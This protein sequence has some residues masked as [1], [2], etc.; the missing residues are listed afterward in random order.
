VPAT[1]EALEYLEEIAQEMTR[2]F[3]ITIREARGRINTQ[4]SNQQFLTPLEVNVLTH[5]EQDVWAGHIYYGRDSFWW[6]GESD[7]Q[8]QPYT[9]DNSCET[10]PQ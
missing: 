8:P 2:L 7:L 10:E 5:E 1:P 6:L 9:E 3:R 4:F